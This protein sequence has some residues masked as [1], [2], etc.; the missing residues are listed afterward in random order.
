[1]VTSNSLT[2]EQHRISVIW[3]ITST[4]SMDYRKLKHPSEGGSALEL[5]AAGFT[6]LLSFQPEA[7]G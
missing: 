5:D 7:C 3:D 4:H 6:N 2:S 1:M